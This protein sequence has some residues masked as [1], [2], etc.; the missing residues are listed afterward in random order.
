MHTGGVE[1]GVAAIKMVRFG[2][3]ARAFVVALSGSLVVSLVFLRGLFVCLMAWG[4]I[5]GGLLVVFLLLF[6]VCLFCW[7]WGFFGGVVVH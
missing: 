6:F 3:G 1:R 7:G 4:F 5:L 2:G